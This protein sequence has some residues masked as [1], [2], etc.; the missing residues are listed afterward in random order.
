MP[1]NRRVPLGQLAQAMRD[2]VTA[3]KRRVRAC[4]YHPSPT[5]HHTPH[6]PIPATLPSPPPPCAGRH[7]GHRR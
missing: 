7:G 5:R 3:T 2:Y 1:I 4:P 6:P